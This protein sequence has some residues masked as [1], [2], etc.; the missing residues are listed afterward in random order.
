MSWLELK[1]DTS[2]QL[3]PALG[4][5]LSEY[6]ALS[7]TFSD[8]RDEPV[9]EP[10]VGTTP[11]WLHTRVIGLFD[12]SS[13]VDAV[14]AQL[15]QRF[16]AAAIT[17]TSVQ[18]LADQAWERTWMDHFVPT[19]FGNRLWICPSWCAPPDP[20]AVNIFMDPGLAFGT[21]THPTTALC[22]E[23]LDAH[24]PENQ[25]VIDYGC[26][27]GILAI[28]A[29]K[30][31][32]QRV[33]GVDHDPQALLATRENAQRNHVENRIETYLPE[34]M[35]NLVADVILANI[36]ANPLRELAAQFARSIKPGGLLVMSGILIEQATDTCA[37]YTSQFTM[38]AAV[39]KQ[40]WAR[41]D[42]TRN[43]AQ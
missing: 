3:A 9:F 32:A 5:A 16:G 7:V 30:L 18:P 40:E 4:D 14:L 19:R 28:A 13:D 31:G 24:P 37:A 29:A 11:L 35:P 43:S 27:S 42:G 1:I 21:G 39:T 41:L 25:L 22:L 10:D 8:T 20:D 23:W 2:A 12:T 17:S 36:L 38:R 6:G 26:G 15:Q 34:Q 33:I